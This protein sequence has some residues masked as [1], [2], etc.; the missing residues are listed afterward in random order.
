LVPWHR[1]TIPSNVV[2]IE[3]ADRCLRFVGSI[4][5]APLHLFSLGLPCFGQTPQWHEGKESST[6]SSLVDVK[7]SAR[8]GAKWQSRSSCLFATRLAASS[9][10]R[11]RGGWSRRRPLGRG[12]DSCFIIPVLSFIAVSAA[13]VEPSVRTRMLPPLSRDSRIL[14]GV[15]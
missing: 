14:P 13:A 5:W 2:G 1:S 7:R 3:V 11:S 8:K 10:G 9:T 6:S 4:G 12:S 15:W